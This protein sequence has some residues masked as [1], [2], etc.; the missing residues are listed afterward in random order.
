MPEQKNHSEYKIAL[1]GDE[2]L[3]RSNLIGNIVGERFCDDCFSTVGVELRYLKINNSIK[4]SS[5][6]SAGHGQLKF[7]AERCLSGGI[8]MAVYIL[9]CTKEAEQNKSTLKQL[10]ERVRKAGNHD[11]SE[12]IVFTKADLLS[13]SKITDDYL[14]AF[15]EFALSSMTCSTKNDGS[16]KSGVTIRDRFL[17]CFADLY[18]KLHLKNYSKVNAYCAEII[19]CLNSPVFKKEKIK[20]VDRLIQLVQRHKEEL[21]HVEEFREAANA[22]IRRIRE[23]VSQ[24]SLVWRLLEKV[25]CLIALILPPIAIINCVYNQK[26]TGQLKLR[27]FENQAEKKLNQL[28]A[29]LKPSLNSRL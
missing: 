14:S 9:D 16:D 13:G 19:D 11:V 2:N 5:F 17:E 7:K 29:L 3:G 8:N 18:S 4:L 28:E 27:F 12:L 25:V 24:Q 23:Q 22:L 10:R 21:T 20:E 6:D 15:D 26:T 1:L